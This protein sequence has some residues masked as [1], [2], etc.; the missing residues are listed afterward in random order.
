MDMET[1]S[2]RLRRLLLMMEKEDARRKR[3]DEAVRSAMRNG[4]AGVSETVI[5][6]ALSKRYTVAHAKKKKPQAKTKRWR[7]LRQRLKLQGRYM[8]LIRN[9]TLEQRAAIRS[10]L[11]KEGIIAALARAKE[12]SIKQ[13]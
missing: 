11:K 2:R 13:G 10:L 5:R 9:L 8:G 4:L 1:T 3:F 7:A 6:K 12:L